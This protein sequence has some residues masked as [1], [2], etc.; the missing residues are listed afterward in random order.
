MTKKI[1]GLTFILIC[2]FLLCE[3]NLSLNKI[4]CNPISHIA[5]DDSNT[6]EQSLE[7]ITD[8]ICIEFCT[9]DMISGHPY[10][11]LFNIRMRANEKSAQN[12]ILRLFTIFVLLC[13]FGLSFF[14]IHYVSF[15]S[16]KTNTSTVIL[17]FIH[18]KDGKK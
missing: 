15:Q 2:A 3:I 13:L 6:H 11:T 7:A 12:N 16:E 4:T 10:D 17:S 14:I 9:P 1:T 8:I 5:S 18:K